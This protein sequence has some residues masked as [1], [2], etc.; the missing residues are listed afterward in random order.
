[1]L[2]AP[3]WRPLDYTPL[4]TPAPETWTMTPKLLPAF[5]LRAPVMTTLAVA[6][7][8]AHGLA[9]VRL[10]HFLSDHMVLQRGAPV[11]IWGTGE[12]G[13]GVRVTFGG[14]QH[15][16]RTGRDGR[17]SVEL[18][19]LDASDQG[20][21][22]V[23]AGSSNS[24][25][26]EDVL[27]GEVWLCSGQSNMVWTVDGAEGAEAAKA[28][29]DD[30]R[31]RMFTGARVST[32]EPQDDLEG[33]W[34]VA[35]PRTVGGFSAT[36]YYFGRDLLATLDVP[37]GLLNVSWGGSSVQAW[38]TMDALAKVPEAKRTL[39]EY[40]TYSPQLN[41]P[42]DRLAG[43]DVDDSDWERASLPAMFKDIGHDIDGV[44][45][46]RREIEVPEG[47]GGKPLRLSL[48]NIDDQDHTYVNG[49]LIGHTD[50]WQRD[51]SYLIPASGT[52]RE[53]LTLAVRVL[54]GSGPGGFG[55]EPSDMHL[56]I[57]GGRS[58]P[59]ALSGEWRMRVGTT[60]NAPPAQHRPSYLYNGMLHPLRR[61]AIKGCIWYQGE[62]NAIREPAVEYYGLF[63][64]F[65]RD[66]RVQLGRPKLPF[67]FVQLPNF[68]RNGDTF[69][70]Y[71]IVR[72]AQLRAFQ[73]LNH[74]GM[75]VTTDIGQADDIHPRNKLDVGRRLASWALARNYRI[76]EIIPTGPIYTE[77]SFR[78]S[79]ALVRFETYGSDLAAKGGELGGF[80]IAGPDK[81]WHPATASFVDGAVSVTSP[82]VK[83]PVAVRYA[84]GN[85][86]ADATLVNAEGL[87]ASP[88]RTD[89]WDPLER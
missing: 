20:R 87:P 80:L 88:F 26:I 42:V 53:R 1:M 17:W 68:S 44:I 36:A 16:T 67:V 4:T 31:I 62:N 25:T 64:A 2:L 7:L 45:W 35:T 75:A 18:D 69:W 58:Q 70:N 3:T 19:A 74:V 65:I 13:E 55:G 60:V 50:G 5:L 61:Y 85:D 82:D 51:R 46:F 6:S 27:V 8:A 86:P 28:S 73:S 57:E 34:L 15:S 49:E 21:T 56:A 66:L 11:P 47:W 14:Q 9:E 10:P 24:I 43:T 76:E 84:W 89:D 72:D 38:T 33:E 23:V 59:L 30:P 77:V 29:A 22:L 32:P 79:H 71:P 54:D 41:R 37:I 83:Q 12:P 63:P 39:D 52:E 48:G 81:V 78:D 40:A